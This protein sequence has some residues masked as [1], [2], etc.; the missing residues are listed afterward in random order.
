MMGKLWQR[1]YYAHIIWDEKFYQNTKA[2]IINIPIH[3]TG[4]EFHTI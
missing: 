2:Y 4:D 3:W 1:N